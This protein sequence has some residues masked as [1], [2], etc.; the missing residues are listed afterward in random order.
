[1]SKRAR[2]RQKRPNAVAKALTTSLYRPKIE[3][4][5]RKASRLIRSAKHK[6]KLDHGQ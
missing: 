3:I 4:D 6:T 2:H 1:M 5:R